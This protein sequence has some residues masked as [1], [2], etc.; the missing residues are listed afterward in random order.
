MGSITDA[1][2]S[3]E[4]A[5]HQSVMGS[6]IVMMPRQSTVVTLFSA[7]SPTVLV[8]PKAGRD[9][10]KDFSSMKTF[11]EWDKEDSQ[12]GLSITITKSM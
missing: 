5:E 8:G 7:T 9:Q 4:E 6:R 10:S 2:V 3:Q 11:A 12:H 1:V